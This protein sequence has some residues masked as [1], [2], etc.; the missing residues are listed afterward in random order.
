MMLIKLKIHSV[1]FACTSGRVDK[2]LK[3]MKCMWSKIV[4]HCPCSGPVHVVVLQL[5]VA[6]TLLQIL[7]GLQHITH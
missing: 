1:P 3:G 2:E 7:C 5:V 4:C 6:C